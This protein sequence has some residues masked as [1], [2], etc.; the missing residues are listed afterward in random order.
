MD[1]F[2]DLLDYTTDYWI[3]GV[4]WVEGY[5]HLRLVLEPTG[6]NFLLCFLLEPFQQFSDRFIRLFKFVGR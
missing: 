5:P 3:N 4:E 6:L 2:K 1:Y